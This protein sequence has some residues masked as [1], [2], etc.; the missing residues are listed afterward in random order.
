M[1]EVALGEL[2]ADRVDPLDVGGR[3]ERGDGQRL[4][5]AAGEQA[6]AVRTREE[7]DLDRDRAD[8][9]DGAAVHAKALAQDELADGLP[10]DEPEQALAEACVAAGRLEQARGLVLVGAGGPDRGGD[11]GPEGL[12]PSGQVVPEPDQE[13]RG[14][15]GVRQR[16]V[17]LGE[18]DAEEPG[19]GPELVVLE[20][21]VALAGDDQ[22]VEERALRDAGAVAEGLLDERDVEADGVADEGGVA[23]E[24]E[25]LARGLGRARGAR[26]VRVGD[27]V[28]LVADDPAAGVHERGPRV[29]D[30]AALDPDRGHLEQVGHLRVGAGRL[31]VH[32]DEFAARLRQV[33]E[34]ED[35]VRHGLEVR[36]QLLLADELAQPVL[37]LDERQ[38]GP[39]CEQDGLGHHVLG[40]DLDARLDHHD[41]VAG[42]G[43]D[44]VELR[45]LQLGVGR[46]EDELAVDPADP[47]GADGALERD[48][49]DRQRGRRGDGAEDVRVV[50]LVRRQDRDDE[51]DVVLV[52]LGEERADRAVREAGREGR[53]LRHPAFALDEAA[54]DL[55]G[56][57]HPLLELDREREEV[58]TGPRQAAVG[59]PENEGVAVAERD[60][61]AGQTGE[62]AG[63]EG[64]GSSAELDLE[65]GGCGHV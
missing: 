3:P 6:G 9:V 50:L 20:V 28:H 48:L 32:D 1:V 51:L 25:D 4:G 37:D 62:L 64:E 24:L 42:A 26:D 55:A 41:G 43:D 2:G 23:D 61:A 19:Q 21:R 58:E 27:A 16:A 56:R 60:C 46:V 30:L 33:G 29:G 38:Q 53:G 40:E 65:R 14:R 35:G 11:A 34:R 39:L 12:D 59:R 7:A 36:D 44:E 57:V 17:V 54:G 45:V 22:R 47:H 13:V 18:L 49:A 52:A 5:L 10:L 8:L 31:D 15:L 63:L